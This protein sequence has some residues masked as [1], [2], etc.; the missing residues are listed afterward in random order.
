MMVR[1]SLEYNNVAI[2]DSLATTEAILKGNIPGGG[3]IVTSG[4]LT[5]ITFY[6]G[7]TESGPFGEAYSESGQIGAVAAGVAKYVETPP[8]LHAAKYIKM[9][10]D[11]AAKASVRFVS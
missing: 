11:A 4:S 6:G 10:G 8:C 7:H 1:D 9:V 3:V 2:T 5:T